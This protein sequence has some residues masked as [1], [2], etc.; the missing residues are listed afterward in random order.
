M[1]FRWIS[2]VPAA[3]VAEMPPHH[4]RSSRPCSGA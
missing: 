1:M 4:A 2:E 3:M